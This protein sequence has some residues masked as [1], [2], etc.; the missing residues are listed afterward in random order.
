MSERGELT[1]KLL[2]TN[3]PAYDAMLSIKRKWEGLLMQ[4]IH[5]VGTYAYDAED[6]SVAWGI[7][8]GLGSLPS[9]EIL[10]TYPKDIEGIQVRYEQQNVGVPY[11]N[12]HVSE[13]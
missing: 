9:E 2:E 6:G 10:D 3:T 7:R 1:G 11:A 13:E 12:G 8:I 5:V 4:D